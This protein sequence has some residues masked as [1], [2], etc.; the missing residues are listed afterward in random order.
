MIKILGSLCH[1]VVGCGLALVILVPPSGANAKSK[2]AVLYSFQGP[3]DG[4]GA[5]ASIIP[6]G[7]GN[8]YGTTAYGGTGSGGQ[9]GLAGCGTVFKLD[10]DGT[11]TVVYSF[12]GGSDGAQPMAGLVADAKGNL[13]GTTRNG[14][15]GGDNGIVF[16]ISAKGK[17]TVLYYFCGQPNCT[18][19]GNPTGGLIADSAG[20]LYGTTQYG[21][22][23]CGGAG[24]GTVFKFSTDGIETV[25]HA[26]TGGLGGSD[27][28]VP[29]A[30]LISDKAGNLYGTTE[31]GGGSG[32]PACNLLGL[33]GCGTVFK[34]GPDG[35]EKVLYTFQ[36]G[37]DGAW[38]EGSLIMDKA[39]RVYGTTSSGGAANAGTVFRVSQKG[40]EKVLL[41]FNGDVGGGEPW[42]GLVSDGA[43]NLYGTTSQG[44]AN[45]NVQC[46][47]FGYTGCGTVFK[48]SA[49]GKATVLYSFCAAP[50][51]ADGA[52]PF[53]GLI[54]DGMGNLIST[55]EYGGTGSCVSGN[56][57]GTVFKIKE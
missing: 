21:G 18:D 53:A 9:C 55:T 11:E 41:T 40:K 27:G 24:C 35:T 2:E 32:V 48:V 56:S 44:G 22:T 8:F 3:P 37:N 49:K 39:G 33:V 43:G 51:C 29:D 47:G 16:K 42:A 20:N 52:L 46:E 10:S 13:Y 57:C 38:P 54:P 5:V 15:A 4:A 26:F 1:S 30:G 45:S 23:G 17:E 6:D 14:G 25:L 50:N 28:A 12:Q 36:G 7:A 19:G 31:D 34:V